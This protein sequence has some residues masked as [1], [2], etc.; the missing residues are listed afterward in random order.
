MAHVV[1]KKSVRQNTKSVLRRHVK[2]I[3]E[4]ALT[5]LSTTDKLLLRILN[6]KL[7]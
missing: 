4:A 1:F 2:E 5:K 7:W 6:P 3:V